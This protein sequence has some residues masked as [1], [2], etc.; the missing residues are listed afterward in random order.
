MPT[1]GAKDVAVA[2]AIGGET[3][4]PPPTRR[5][6]SMAAAVAVAMGDVEIESTLRV[7]VNASPVAVAIGAVTVTD[8]PLDSRR[9]TLIGSRQDGDG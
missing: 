6:G 7:G 3:K 1:E 9:R 2:A 4:A 5:A 8:P